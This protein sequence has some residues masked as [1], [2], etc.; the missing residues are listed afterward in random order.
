MKARKGLLEIGVV[1][2]VAMVGAVAVA[3]SLLTP[4]DVPKSTKYTVQNFQRMPASVSPETQTITTPA[5]SVST[6]E[7]GCEVPKHLTVKSHQVRLL[8]TLCAYSD[9]TQSISVTN[10]SNG[11]RATVFQDEKS[12]H[13]LIGVT[14]VQKDGDDQSFEIMVDNQI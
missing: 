11:H 9:N 14:L 3:N 6:L 2:A 10:T 7:I 5:A 12:F 4:P 1:A 8:Q 13:N